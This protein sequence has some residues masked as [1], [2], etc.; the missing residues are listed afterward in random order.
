MLVLRPLFGA[1]GRNFTFDPYGLYSYRSIVVGD[2]VYVGPGAVITST[3]PRGICIG[4]KV[5]FGPN[6]SLIG[7]DHN[8]A[9]AGRYMY[10]VHEKR[11]DDDL[12]IVIEDDVWVGSGAIILKGVTVGRGSVI[13]AGAVVTRDIPPYSIAG[14]V[15]AKVL[16]RRGSDEEILA[17]E[18]ALYPPDA[19][20]RFT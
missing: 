12:P 10:D 18:N 11:S 13:A 1:Y 5:M 6:V 9:L 4:S 16:K 2:D 15:P 19:R 3:R 7:G 17:H 8:T 20:I 14:G